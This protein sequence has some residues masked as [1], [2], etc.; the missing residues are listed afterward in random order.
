MQHADPRTKQGQFLINWAFGI[1][2]SYGHYQGNNLPGEGRG[3]P[4][5]PRKKNPNKEALHSVAE[6]PRQMFVNFAL[7][8]ASEFEATTPWDGQCIERRRQAR[9]ADP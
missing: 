9:V 1:E 3:I 4:S 6:I 2:N 7:K 8:R 5:D